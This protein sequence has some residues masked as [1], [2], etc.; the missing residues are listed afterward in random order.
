MALAAQSPS[1]RRLDPGV[2]RDDIVE[3][4][5]ERLTTKATLSGTYPNAFTS[6]CFIGELLPPDLALQTRAAQPPGDVMKT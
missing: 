3:L 6:E 5:I 4:I 1:R 2:S